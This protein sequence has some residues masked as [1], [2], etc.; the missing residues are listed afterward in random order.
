[1][2]KTCTVRCDPM[3]GELCSIDTVIYITDINRVRNALYSMRY[4]HLRYWINASDKRLSPTN[5]SQSNANMPSWVP[6]SHRIVLIISH[7]SRFHSFPSSS[8]Q[9]TSPFSL[10]LPLPLPPRLLNLQSNLPQP[11]HP[12]RTNHPT[13]N[14]SRKTSP[15]TRLISLP[16]SQ[17]PSLCT[18]PLRSSSTFRASDT[19]CYN[20][21]DCQT[22]GIAYLGKGVED[23]AG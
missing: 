17:Y 12:P 11:P 8:L 7:Q 9:I 16:Q 1:M 10:P 21:S 6:S 14:T 15:K 22:N 3:F 18:R 4:V 19:R 5:V 13:N 23:A 20:R 2:S